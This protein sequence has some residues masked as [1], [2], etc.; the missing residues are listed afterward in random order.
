MLLLFTLF[1]FAYSDL[2][3]N[4]ENIGKQL[5]KN[6]QAS[7]IVY[8]ESEQKVVVANDEGFICT[9]SLEGTSVDCTRVVGPGKQD[10]EDLCLVR[11]MY[12][13]R[14]VIYIALGTFSFNTLLIQ[15][16]LISTPIFTY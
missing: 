2:I 12:K 3:F 13:Q 11:T 6:T 16:L 7:G 15:L 10:F 8:L 1:A 14:G 9:M 5:P 4:T